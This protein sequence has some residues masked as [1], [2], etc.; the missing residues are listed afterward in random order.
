MY[1]QTAEEA[2]E[3]FDLYQADKDEER[4]TDASLLFPVTSDASELPDWAER[5]I[6]VAVPGHDQGRLCTRRCWL[7]V[8]GT[9]PP[10]PPP[11]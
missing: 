1:V 8:G 3:V 5:A 7:V 6:S 11:P 9:A 10:P 4:A 2:E